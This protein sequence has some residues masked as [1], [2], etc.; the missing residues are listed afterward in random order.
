MVRSTDGVASS[1]VEA[2]RFAD[3]AARALAPLPPSPLAESLA[4]L[5]RQLLD[6]V[7]DDDGGTQPPY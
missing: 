3:D 4:G 6:D 2:R 5:A 7:V 1:L